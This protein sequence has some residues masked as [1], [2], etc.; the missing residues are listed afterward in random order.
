MQESRE[1]KLEQE[2]NKYHKLIRKD[3]T[4]EDK[5]TASVK[6]IEEANGQILLQFTPHAGKQSSEER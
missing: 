6:H 5:N 1:D 2:Q 4:A 3:R